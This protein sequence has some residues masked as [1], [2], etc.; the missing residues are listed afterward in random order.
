MIN[1]ETTENYDLLTKYDQVSKEQQRDEFSPAKYS[2]LD[3]EN[4][5]QVRKMVKSELQ[6]NVLTQRP[7]DKDQ[8]R[9]IEVSD[10]PVVQLRGNYASTNNAY[11]ES[12]GT[13]PIS[14]SGV[15]AT[16]KPI[17][18][19][20]HHQTLSYQKAKDDKRYQL[21]LQMMPSSE[22]LDPKL[23]YGFQQKK[24]IEIEPLEKPKVQEQKQP[25][26]QMK[27]KK[28]IKA[29]QKEGVKEQTLE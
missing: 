21:D 9:L 1:Q 6:P 14:P 17:A 29:K 15:N 28:T 10:R 3:F 25:D 7:Q 22:I 18:L 20:A 12:E 23:A 13:S 5:L 4:K 26:Q 16:A 19:D 27:A 2:E 11:T 24:E 8:N